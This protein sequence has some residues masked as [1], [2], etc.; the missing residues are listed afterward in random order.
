MNYAS[1]I[2]IR[3]R[4]SSLAMVMILTADCA[5]STHNSDF[6]KQGQHTSG[7]QT[8]AQK[9]PY[10]PRLKNPQQKD[11]SIR[12]SSPEPP[13]TKVRHELQYRVS[14]R[15]TSRMFFMRW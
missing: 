9:I 13:Q 8:G 11:D 7:Q 2:S 4:A 6:A 10:R 12:T 1:C 15:T 14:S 3:D 5:S